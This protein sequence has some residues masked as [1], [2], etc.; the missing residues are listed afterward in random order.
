MV[1]FS[2]TSA[3]ASGLSIRVSGTSSTSNMR[4]AAA[5]ARCSAV[6]CIES[7]RTGSKN[8]CT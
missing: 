7:M 8:F 2:S 1:G 5:V 3:T 4:L 6:Y